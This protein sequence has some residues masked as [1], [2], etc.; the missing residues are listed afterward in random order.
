MLNAAE[1]LHVVN[2]VTTHLLSQRK[3][4]LPQ[5]RL[6]SPHLSAPLTTLVGQNHRAPHLWQFVDDTTASKF[7]PKGS[8]STVNT[9]I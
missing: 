2:H 4:T 6:K 5:T 3:P 9:R 7:T 1:A 8:A